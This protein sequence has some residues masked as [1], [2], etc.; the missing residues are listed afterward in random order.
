MV[1]VSRWSSSSPSSLV[2]WTRSIAYPELQLPM[3][4]MLKR[5]LK[6]ASKPGGNKNAKLNQ[7][8]LLLVQKSEA[9]ARWIEER[10]NKINFS[11]KD[12]TEVEAFV[13]DVQW[14]DTPLGAFVVS[15][16]ESREERR[17]VLEQGRKEQERR[18]RTEE[19]EDSDIEI[20]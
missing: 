11:P 18:K 6:T 13:K 9:N 1:L 15:Q 4:V 16:K 17:K 19:G 7:A 2:L 5:W 8:L 14:Q 12:R 3:I 10:R 20:A